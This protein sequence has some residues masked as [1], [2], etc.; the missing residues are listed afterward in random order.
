MSKCIHALHPFINRMKMI[1]MAMA[2]FFINIQ[3]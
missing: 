1:K 3:Y 2:S